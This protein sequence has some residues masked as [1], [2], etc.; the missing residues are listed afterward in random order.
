M[1]FFVLSSRLLT[2]GQNV[3]RVS[4][5]L[6][7]NQIIARGIFEKQRHSKKALP[8]RKQA[9]SAWAQQQQLKQKL[10]Q[11]KVKKKKIAKSW[12][13]RIIDNGP[14]P[15]FMYIRHISTILKPQFSGKE[16]WAGLLALTGV[17]FAVLLM[18]NEENTDE[19]WM[20]KVGTRNYHQMY[21]SSTIYDRLITLTFIVSLVSLP[22]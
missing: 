17:N 3:R 1:A 8:A 12:G 5:L 15:R 14:V 11:E 6:T 7:R 18:W 20:M 13:D 19:E 10:Q 22:V 21:I 9:P 2:R 16:A 4:P